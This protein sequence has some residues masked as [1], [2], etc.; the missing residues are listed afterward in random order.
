MKTIEEL[1]KENE[2]LRTALMQLR[3]IMERPASNMRFMQIA[4]PARQALNIIKLALKLP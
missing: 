1:T 3:A 4:G 2:E